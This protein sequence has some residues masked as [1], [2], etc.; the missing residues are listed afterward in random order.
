MAPAY[1]EAVKPNAESLA[2][3]LIDRLGFNSPILMCELVKFG[4]AFTDRFE[5]TISFSNRGD[6]KL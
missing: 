5:N 1:H 2:G 4:Q 3:S 6:F